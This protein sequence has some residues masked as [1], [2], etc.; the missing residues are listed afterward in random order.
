MTQEKTTGNTY[1]WDNLLRLIPGYDPFATAGDCYFDEGKA[2]HAIGFIEDCIVHVKGELGGHPFIL[3]KWEKCFVANVFGWMRPDGTRRYREVLLFV[4]RKNGKTLLG[5]A[6]GL[7][8]LCCDG[9]HGA[10]IYS[11]AADREQAGLIWDIAK[12]QVKNEPA[13]SEACRP[14][15]NSIVLDSTA[16]FF[17]PISRDANTKHGYSG[18][19]VLI[20]ELHAQKTGELVDVLVTSTAARKQPLIIY[21]TTSDFERPGSICNEKHDYACKVRDES[22]LPPE[23]RSINDFAFLPVIYE[24]S[25]DD[26]WESEEIWAK[27]NPNLGVSVSLEYLRREC[28]KAQESPARR[29]T[30]KR[31]HLNIRTETEV[32]Y[33]PMDK[34]DSCGGEYSVEELF[35]LLKGETC[36][37][38]LDLS[39]NTDLTSLAL[40]FPEKEAALSFNWVPGETAT[41]RQ[42]RDRVPYENWIEAGYIK[43]TQGETVDYDQM[44]LDINELNK[45][46]HIKEIAFDRWNAQQLCNQLLSDG[47]DMVTFG[48]GTGSMNAPTKRLETL[49][50]SKKIQHGGN[51]VLRWAASNLVVD[52]NAAGDVKPNKKKSTEKIDPVVALI[53]AI[54]RAI[55]EPEKKES[56]YSKRGIIIL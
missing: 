21:M 25:I 24:A 3:E 1:N 13:L 28:A 18:H 55:I 2:L 26:D 9:E 32:Q 11:A 6:I 16:S 8:L 52:L 36:Y 42:R 56:V 39:A 47:F 20:D 45:F 15:L 35:E 37:G 49:I 29:N 19:G 46:F 33:I 51:P 38:G 10:E 48:Q 27:A 41:I 40:Y 54:G 43:K 22:Q 50:K 12:F 5:A 34:W 44:R 7:Y 17:K 14:Y 53:M 31:L 30:F 4:P 23:K